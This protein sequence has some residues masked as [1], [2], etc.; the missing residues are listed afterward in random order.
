MIGMEK[1]IDG[2]HSK[3]IKIQTYWKNIY[4]SSL[5]LI[6]KCA[7][8]LDFLFI[9]YSNKKEHPQVYFWEEL[10]HFHANLVNGQ[11]SPRLSATE[12]AT[13]LVTQ[14]IIV[15]ITVCSFETC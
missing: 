1:E 6:K 14:R 10:M 7:K 2:T 8:K 9:L 13:N 15:F 11:I 4:C 3:C 12:K 5:K